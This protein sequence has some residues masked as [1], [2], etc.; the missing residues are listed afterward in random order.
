MQTMRCSTPG[1]KR[2]AIACDNTTIE[3]RL[4]LQRTV[5]CDVCGQADELAAMR[6]CGP[7]ATQEAGNATGGAEDV[8]GRG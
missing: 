6:R 2:I 4:S 1:C 7:R 8:E 3:Q 5:K